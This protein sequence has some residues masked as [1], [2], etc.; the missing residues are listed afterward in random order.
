MNARRK[1]R[2][3]PPRDEECPHCGT[4]C[5]VREGNGV[6]EC[7]ECGETFEVDLR[8]AKHVHQPDGIG[9]VRA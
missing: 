9:F 4:E 8:E 7:P 1:N 6:Y 5:E 2:S 3:I